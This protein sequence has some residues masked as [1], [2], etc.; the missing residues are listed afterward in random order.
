ML[1]KNFYYLLILFISITGCK[2]NDGELSEDPKDRYALDT[3]QTEAF[4]SKHPDFSV[5]KKE[6]ADLYEKHQSK[7][8]WY[9]KDGRV[10]FAD[11]L[12]DHANALADEGL[13][14]ALPYR[15]EIQDVFAKR[16]T[17]KPTTEDELL[18]SSL[19]FFYTHQVFDG[20][21][22]KAD[23]RKMGWYLPRQKSSYVNY[24]DTLVKEPDL[25]KKDLSENFE[26]Y[27]NLRTALKKYREIKAK[28]GWETIAFEKEIKAGEKSP[29]VASVR[30]RLAVT[31]ELKSDNQSDVY[32]QELQE[33]VT[34]YQS[35]RGKSGNTIDK[36]LVASLNVPVDDRIR[37]IAVNMERCRWVSPSINNAQDYV[38]V[39]VPAFQLRYVKDGEERLVSNVVVGE[40]INKTVIFSG[41]MSYLVF[42]PYWNI[43][44]SI[45]KKEIEPGIAKDP[46]YLSKHNMERV[47]KRIRQKP[48]DQNSLGLVKFMFPNTNNIY[49]HDS[50]AKALFNA[51]DRAKSHGCIRVQKAK[52]LANIILEDDK[53]WNAKKI[54]EAMHAGSEKHYPLKKKIPVIIAYFTAWADENGNVSFFED[55]YNRDG[56]LAKALYQ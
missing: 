28:G 52:E 45:I 8:I 23:A 32:D 42:S 19:Y 38:A 46:N 4:F 20:K 54:D 48:G 9:D 39:N 2:R 43:P 36:D 5:Y 35:A 6:I 25:L 55:I 3:G 1:K 40:E 21:V 56:H 53:N 33:A 12:Y 41:N 16:D 10:E 51:E 26:Q 13:P 24:L 31:G 30:K 7:M 18:I 14:S 44:P 22:G 34:K 50:P 11:V 37:I 29:I 27:Y 49:L 47:G 17:K 15:P